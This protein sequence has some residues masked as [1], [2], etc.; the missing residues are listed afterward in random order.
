M[1]ELILSVALTVSPVVDMAAAQSL[2]GA[3]SRAPAAS[4]SLPSDLIGPGELQLLTLDGEFAQSVANGGGAAFSSWF[5]ED[6]VTLNNGK[7]AVLGKRRIAGNAVWKAQEYQFTWLP[8]GARMGPSDD[9]GFTWGHYDTHTKDSKGV[10]V[11]T[12]GRYITIWKRMPDGKWK[13]ALDAS[14]NEPAGSGL[15]SP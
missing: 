9:M 7:G 4:A 1:R 10:P 3:Q 12:S 11:T 6:A 5:A 2:S 14:A 13:V 8:E 15:P